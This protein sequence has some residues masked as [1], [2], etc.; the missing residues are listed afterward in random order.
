MDLES[1]IQNIFRKTEAKFRDAAGSQILV[2]KQDKGDYMG[3]IGPGCSKPSL[4]IID[5]TLTLGILKSGLELDIQKGEI[6]FP[7]DKH[8]IKRGNYSS[9]KWELKEGPISLNCC[10][11]TYLRNYVKTGSLIP[12]QVIITVDHPDFNHGL[13]FYLGKEVEKYFERETL[14][15]FTYLDTSY[16]EALEL[17]GKKAP[18]RFRKEY[19]K[20]VYQTNVGI[21]NKLEELTLREDKLN[22]E[23]KKINDNIKNKGVALEDLD[24]GRIRYIYEDKL[25]IYSG[26]ERSK[27]NK[28]REEIQT[29]LRQSIELGMHKEDLTIKQKPGIEINVPAYINGMCEKYKVDIPK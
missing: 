3:T 28:T 18:A 29:Y 7:T 6:I 9:D 17:L 5:E 1:D 16:V 15:V 19:D 23:I 10:E 11:F 4:T 14:L 12:P 26:I 8:V 2:V 21:I 25:G 20:E 27:L 22:C 13:R 24:G